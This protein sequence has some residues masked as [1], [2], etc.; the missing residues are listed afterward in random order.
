MF[1][2]PIYSNSLQG[3]P[4]NY[5][6][7]DLSV[8]K[9]HNLANSANSVNFI[10]HSCVVGSVELFYLWAYKSSAPVSIY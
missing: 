9:E 5:T 4:V 2:F 1:I 7:I 6:H 8:I 3:I 10:N